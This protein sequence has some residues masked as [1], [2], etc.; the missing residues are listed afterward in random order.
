MISQTSSDRSHVEAAIKSLVKA[1]LIKRTWA[2]THKQKKM[3]ELRDKGIELSKIIVLTGQYQGAF[4][5]FW[6]S[7]RKEFFGFNTI[8]ALKWHGL[9]DAEIQS[10]LGRVKDIMHVMNYCLSNLFIVLTYLKASFSNSASLTQAIIDNLIATFIEFISKQISLARRSG[11]GSESD[12]FTYHLILPILNLLSVNRINV[13]LFEHPQIGKK[14]K[15]LLVSL[16]NLIVVP[17]GEK[18]L[19]N[20]IDRFFTRYPEYRNVAPKNDEIKRYDDIMET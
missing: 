6:K 14:T 12:V 10:F 1:H 7:Y 13:D 5:E 20:Y 19:T 4:E 18:N 17:L 15:G 3:N 2:T 16:L 11:P 8:K 9:T